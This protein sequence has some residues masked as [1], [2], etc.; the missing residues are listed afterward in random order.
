MITVCIIGKNIRKTVETL[1]ENDLSDIDQIITTTDFP[2]ET[3]IPV[4]VINAET[5]NKSEIKN[6]MIKISKGDYILW[7]SENTELEDS[8]VEELVEVVE[9]F[10]DA[11]I[12]YPNEILIIGK[13]EDVK[14]FT[15]WYSNEKSLIQSLTLENYLP[16]WGVITKKEMFLK[17]GMFDENFEDYEFYDFIYKNLKNLKLK[18]SDLSFV[19]NRITESFIDTSYRSKTLRDILGIYDWK[20]EIFPSLSWDKNEKLAFGTAYTIIGDKLYNYYD[21]YNASDYYRK[22]LLS[23]HNQISLKKL[24]NTLVQMGLFDKA[25]ELT[26]KKQGLSQKE[27]DE[28]SQRIKQFKELVLKLEKAVEEGKAGDILVSINDI[29]SIYSGA[30]IYNILG[31]IYALKGELENSYRFFYKALTMN[32][33]DEDILKNLIDIAERLGRKDKVK[34]LINRL[35]G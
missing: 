22:S 3:D 5:E 2:L 4:E 21:L 32:P 16:E 8:T 10:P 12:I 15:D 11:D 24:I 30:P 35:L 20:K 28:V 9:D 13:E 27:V 18:N 33:L 6:K 23:Y 26:T 7:L 1:L 17:L 29:V 19:T 25:L 34:G 14:T 31:V